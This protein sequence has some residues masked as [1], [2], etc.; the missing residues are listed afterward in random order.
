MQFRFRYL[1]FLC[2]GLMACNAMTKRTSENTEEYLQAHLGYQDDIT[3]SILGFSGVLASKDIKVIEEQHAITLQEL[4]EVRNK[5]NRIKPFSKDENLHAVT[6]QLTDFYLNIFQKDYKV[7]MQLM[8]KNP[9]TDADKLEIKKLITKIRELK[10]PVNE[11]FLKTKEAYRK[12][13]S[14]PEPINEE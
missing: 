9:L 4:N 3:T 7:I 12:K 1:I 5:V 2:F 14:L 10:K 13:F 8:T 6:L 11:A